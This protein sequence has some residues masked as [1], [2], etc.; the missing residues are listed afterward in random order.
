[1]GLTYKDAGVD[2]DRG[3]ALVDRIVP[4]AKSTRTP[5][6]LDDVGGFAAFVASRR[7]SKNRCSSRARTE[8]ARSSS[9]RSTLVSTARWAS[10]SSRCA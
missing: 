5:F 4:L 8:W 10:T 6:V 2:I 9:S 7:G 3:D 1:M